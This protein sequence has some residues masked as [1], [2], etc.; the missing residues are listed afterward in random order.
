MQTNY[1]DCDHE[2]HYFLTTQ[3][4]YVNE[5]G[6]AVTITTQ[7]NSTNIFKMSYETKT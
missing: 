6:L 4:I 7:P 2:R 3:E 5:V 1:D